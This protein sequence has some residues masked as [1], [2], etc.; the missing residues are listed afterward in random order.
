MWNLGHFLLKNELSSSLFY[1]E[2]MNNKHGWGLVEMLVLSGI[3]VLFLGI[4]V[5]LV[6]SFQ[7]SFKSNNN[8]YK[9]LEDKLVDKTQDYLDNYYDDIITSDGVVIFSDEMQAYGIDASLIDKN[10]DYCKGYAVVS[11]SMG[12][13]KINPYISCKEYETEGYKN[14]K[15]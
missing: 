8:F 6:V 10:G 5:M 9:Q 3:I 12:N 14:E 13:L 11:K 15:Q 2:C 7:N 1:G 4:V